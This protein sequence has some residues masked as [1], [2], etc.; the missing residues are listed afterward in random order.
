MLNAL[1]SGKEN[2]TH[3]AHSLTKTRSPESNTCGRTDT[4]TLANPKFIFL[5]NSDG[6]AYSFFLPSGSKNG[7]TVRCIGSRMIPATRVGHFSFSLSLF[8]SCCPYAA[9]ARHTI[10]TLASRIKR[11]PVRLTCS[12]LGA[13]SMASPSMVCVC[14]DVGERHGQVVKC[15]AIERAHAHVHERTIADK[16]ESCSAEFGKKKIARGSGEATKNHGVW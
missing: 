11:P 3:S 2:H 8:S 12:I 5:T 1:T 4:Q 16:T 15:C 13:R 9:T 10:R 6:V 14:V 7:N